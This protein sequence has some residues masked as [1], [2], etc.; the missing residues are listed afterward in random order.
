MLTGAKLLVEECFFCFLKIAGKSFLE[1][2][3]G[4]PHDADRTDEIILV[5]DSLGKSF[6]RKNNSEVLA[7]TE[8]AAE[9]EALRSITNNENTL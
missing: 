3:L 4:K 8:C 7:Q 1:V 9:K 6:E 5:I 2:S